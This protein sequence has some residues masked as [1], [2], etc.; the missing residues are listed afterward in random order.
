MW[1]KVREPNGRVLL[2]G[3]VETFNISVETSSVTFT[4]TKMLCP[5]VPIPDGVVRDMISEVP[6][7]GF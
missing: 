7:D 2:V 1:I 6:A 5:G 4:C 3:Q